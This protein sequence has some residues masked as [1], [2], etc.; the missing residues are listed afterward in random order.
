M[1]S[2]IAVAIPDIPGYVGPERIPTQEEL[3]SDESRALLQ[4]GINLAKL[5]PALKDL[6]NAIRVD[7][8]LSGEQQQI[9]IHWSIHKP[10]Q[11]WLKAE[12]PRQRFHQWPWGNWWTVRTSRYNVETQTTEATT[13]SLV[14]K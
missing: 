6:I 7:N 14:I 10:L 11:N 12:F 3:M 13:H 1:N 5:K 9:A 2:N 8:A 4:E